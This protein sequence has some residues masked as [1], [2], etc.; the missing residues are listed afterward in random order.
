M[1]Q[2]IKTKIVLDLSFFFILIGLFIV[3]ISYFKQ[4]DL[5]EKF[6]IDVAKI[7]SQYFQL[8]STEIQRLTLSYKEKSLA[9]LSSIELASLQYQLDLLPNSL[10]I[11]HQTYLTDGIKISKENKV[12]YKILL[13]NQRIYDS[14]ISRGEL[15]EA[16]PIFSDAINETLLGKSFITKEYTDALG[17]WI[18]VLVPIFDSNKKV[19]AIYGI[20]VSTKQMNSNL[21][22]YILQ[23]SSIGFLLFCFS[24]AI[25]YLRFKHILKPLSHLKN[26][27][28]KVLNGNFNSDNFYTNDDEIGSI[29]ASLNQLTNQISTYIDKIRRAGKY[30]SES[31][32]ILLKSSTE[33][34][35]QSK[36]IADLVSRLNQVINEQIN[37]LE[38][39]KL[40]VEQESIALHRIAVV[41]ASVNDAASNS[42]LSAESGEKNLHNLSNEMN[43][44]Q[45]SI[46]KSGSIAIDLDNSSNQIGKIVESITQIASQTNLLALNAAIEA[47]RAGDQGKGFAVV[48]DEV[49]KL[50]DKST[51]SAKQITSMLAEIRNKIQNL[52]ISVQE[53][54]STM[55]TGIQSIKSAESNFKDI[56][57]LAKSVSE[58]ISDVS[59]S[60]EEISASSD[61][62]ISNMEQNLVIS[63]EISNTTKE[64]SGSSEMQI[65]AMHQIEN[66]AKSLGDHSSDLEKIVKDF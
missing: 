39:S 34:I 62:L 38:E 36:E 65:I 18:S 52:V 16:A 9:T 13:A 5:F 8:K 45:S 51:H 58:Q 27:S 35:E 57:E 49:S 20:D 7:H 33:S 54:E 22:N 56:V 53:T 63:N 37:S 23:I 31:G 61:E 19:I 24:I 47:A 44:V 4:K 41:A 14:G 12:F 11:V 28:D 10:E 50:A 64:I 60:V 2:S 21:L 59:A 32:S 43:N 17:D 46:R 55:V 25:L 3:I 42:F 48:A 29:F 40:A 66:K 1:K 15:Y 30:M 6:Y 26:F